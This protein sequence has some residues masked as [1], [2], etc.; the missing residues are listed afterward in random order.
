MKYLTAASAIW[1]LLIGLGF[2]YPNTLMRISHFETLQPLVWGPF[3]LMVSLQVLKPIWKKPSA[4]AG[5]DALI[6]RV[7]EELDRTLAMPE[8]RDRSDALRELYARF[9]N[10]ESVM[11]TIEGTLQKKHYNDSGGFWVLELHLK[12]RP[13]SLLSDKYSNKVEGFVDCGGEAGITV[14]RM[15]EALK[16]GD[17]VSLETPVGPS[18]VLNSDSTY[19]QDLKKDLTVFHCILK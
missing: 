4:P 19:G 12:G 17:K 6:T 15:I 10:E 3:L 16:I 7:T 11:L 2:Y 1:G 13:N 9:H 8:G 18:I 14:S 5:L